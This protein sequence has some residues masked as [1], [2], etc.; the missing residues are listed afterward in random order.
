MKFYQPDTRAATPEEGHWDVALLS[1]F[2][3]PMKV[4]LVP[5]CH[6]R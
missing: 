3:I 6:F 1:G 4:R 5:K 2:V